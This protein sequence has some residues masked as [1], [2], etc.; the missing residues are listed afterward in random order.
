MDYKP[1]RDLP[2]F[3]HELQ[4]LS[5]VKLADKILS[6]RNEKVSP[7]SVEKWFKRHPEIHEQL[8]KEFIGALPDEKQIVDEA[9][10][11]N[12]NFEHLHSIKEWLLYM[13]TRRGHKGKP[14]HPE[15]VKIQVRLLRWVCQRFQ[16]HPDRLCFRDV[17]EMFMA[18]EKDK[19]YKHWQGD[20]KVEGMDTANIR[21][22]VKDFLK[23]KGAPGWE[24]IG[25]GKPSGYG[26][27]KNLW[28]E[29]EIVKQ[30]LDWTVEQNFEIGVI[31]WLMYA[32]GMRISAVLGAQIKNFKRG[33][34][35]D[36]LAVLE[37]F[38]ETPTFKLVKR[39][40]DMVQKAI[41]DKT[42][43]KIFHV[44]LKDDVGKLNREALKKF[45]PSLEPEIEMPNHFY[46]H[47]CAQHLRK[48]TGGN[49]GLCASIMHCS[50]QSFDESY[51]GQTEQ[52][53]EQGE[54]KYLPLLGA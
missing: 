28:A 12:G 6:T 5:W 17:Q 53:V 29:P 35:W 1:S 8:K 51:G 21:R 52:E 7:D 34:E 25:V 30:M 4:T 18:L 44:D 43:G 16:K 40:G 2:A 23:S 45:L 42:E 49:T 22:A 11:Q 27:Y 50:K 13:N 15:Y 26:Q 33:K 20:L 54:N 10:F 47:M 14:L 36:F 32:T 46:R 9:T 24:K 39:V 41:G 38:R 19:K 48:L 31:D 37:K 3:A